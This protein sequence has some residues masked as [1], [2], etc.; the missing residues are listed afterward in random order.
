MFK[1]KTQVSRLIFFGIVASSIAVLF[2]ACS[3]GATSGGTNR[4]FRTECYYDRAVIKL[5]TGETIAGKVESWRDFA[6]CDLLQVKIDD[7]TYLVHSN[8]CVLIKED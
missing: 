6:D 3:H 4:I 1:T 7:T 2:T 5:P 8:N